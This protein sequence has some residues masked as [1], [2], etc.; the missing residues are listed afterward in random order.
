MLKAISLYLPLVIIPISVSA[1]TAQVIRAGLERLDWKETSTIDQSIEFS[2][3]RVDPRHLSVRLLDSYGIL[4]GGR[5]FTG[6][7]LRDLSAKVNALVIINGGATASFTSPVPVGLLKID[8]Q[9]R[10]KTGSSKTLTGVLCLSGSSVAIQPVSAHPE[11]GC[12]SAL[13]AG[14]IVVK[15][16]ANAVYPSERSERRSYRRSIAAVDTSGRLLLITCSEAHL[17]E[18]ARCLLEHSKTLQVQDAINLD[19]DSSSGMI[20]SPLGGERHVR[21]YIQGFRTSCARQDRR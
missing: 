1:Q 8:G 3:V 20:I 13:Q 11:A 9:L 17:Y 4:S 14:P 7:N 2:A 10:S 15:A 6:F 5:S 18:V 12:T 21:E 19:G 16:S